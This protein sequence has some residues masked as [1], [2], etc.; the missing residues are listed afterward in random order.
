MIRSIARFFRTILRMN[1]LK[2]FY[3]NFH[4][5]PF[6]QAIRFPIV[7]YGK[8]IIHDNIGNIKINTSN[9]YPN[10]IK[11]GYRWLDLWPISYV[12]TQLSLLGNIIFRGPAIIS[13]GVNLTS[14]SMNAIIDIGKYCIIGAGCMVKS[15]D[16]ILIGDYTR[17]AGGCIIMNSNMH[18]I[19]EIESGIIKKTIGKISIGKFCWI[20]PN[21][22]VSKGAYIPNYSITARSSYISNDFSGFGENLFLVGSPAKPSSKKVQRIF[23]ASASRKLT[24]FFKENPDKK[25]YEESPGVI[26]F[27]ENDIDTF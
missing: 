11:I 7:V 16:E 17:I 5:L 4:F 10:M 13:G 1:I 25:Y 26:N 2:T 14:D 20:N 3:V 6:K 8:L 19:K 22:V 21:S 27:D 15:L 24:K 12:P 18:F 9:I 23:S